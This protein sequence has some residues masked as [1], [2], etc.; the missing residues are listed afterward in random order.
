VTEVAKVT[1]PG[2]PANPLA[3]HATRVA[4]GMYLKMAD[5]R[6]VRT[7]GRAG[8]DFVR[9][10]M[11]HGVSDPAAVRTL[12][13]AAHEAGL[14]VSVRVPK[15]DDAIAAAVRAGAESLTFP[16]V[17]SAQDATRLCG[18]VGPGPL[19]S[20]QIESA[21][22][23]RNLDGIA[24]T[25]GVGMLQCGRADLSRDLRLPDR[26]LQA[27]RRYDEQVFA[28]ARAA[29]IL[30]CLHAPP[31]TGQYGAEWLARGADCLT[32]GADTQMIAAMLQQS[33]EGLLAMGK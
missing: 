12:T 23:L 10:D 15:S 22:G 20:V 8:L 33:M 11:C 9:I 32:L 3:R 21:S 24:R 19:V 16:S 31:G 14:R 1:P 17:D 2:G 30:F 18:L 26:S 27:L 13:E 28:T 7:A 6:T 25:P 4:V 29:E 5:V